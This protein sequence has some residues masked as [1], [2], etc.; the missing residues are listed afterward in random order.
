MTDPNA[1]ATLLD[2][3][4]PNWLWRI[5]RML[6]RNVFLFGLIY[7][8]RG[9]EKLP[10][11]GALFLINHQSFLDPLLVGLPLS[12]PVSYLARDNLFRVP[13]IGWILRQTYVIPIR[14]NAATTDALRESIRRIEHGFYVGI[15]PEGTRTRDGSI[16]PFKPGFLAMIRRTDVPIVPI[17][18]AGSNEALPRKSCCLRPRRVHVIF[19][20][21][22]S[23]DELT[24]LSQKENERELVDFL[25]SRVVSLH[26]EAERWRNDQMIAHEAPSRIPFD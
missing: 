9:F 23:R 24:S 12:R 25:R 5:I 10:S 1:S 16:G 2:P 22:I 4:R 20:N 19:G 21:P 6:L 26:E 14:R 7:R 11:G 3:I 8:A 18:I 17:G 15:F 13:L